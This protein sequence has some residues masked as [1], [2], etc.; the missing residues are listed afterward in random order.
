[1]ADPWVDRILKQYATCASYTD[2]GLIYCGS[3]VGGVQPL[4]GRFETSFSRV[5]ER[6]EFW[7]DV[8]PAYGG[9]QTTVDAT[10]KVCRENRPGR[11][12]KTRPSTSDTRTS[13]AFAALS[14][15][16]FG[17]AQFGPHHLLPHIIGGRGIETAKTVAVGE[18]TLMLR[19]G[20]ELMLF[21]RRTLTVKRFGTTA[22][23][24]TVRMMQAFAMSD[25]CLEHFQTLVTYDAVTIVS[26]IRDFG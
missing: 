10:G 23:P 21:D 25:D 3:R 20:T 12:A 16:T 4:I 7:F 6:L 15:V 5:G 17:A 11:R 8:E 22:A 1:M 13:L 24:P 2:R 26:A 18:E 19:E 9:G 14:G